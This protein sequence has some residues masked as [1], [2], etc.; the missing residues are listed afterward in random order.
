MTY[1]C[2]LFTQLPAR[3]PGFSDLAA[4]Q[5]R[6]IDRLLAACYR[7]LRPSSVSPSGTTCY[8]LST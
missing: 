3:T 8:V 2:T 7:P 5:R 6:K 4:A 1:S